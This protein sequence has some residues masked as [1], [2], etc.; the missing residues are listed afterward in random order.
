[1]AGE[2]A[3]QFLPPGT[4]APCPA[5][6]WENGR[7]WCGLIRHPSKHLGLRFDADV[8]L[9]EHFLRAIGAHQGCGMDDQDE[10]LAYS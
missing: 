10:P 9:T 2:I 1:M 4:I 5:L 7:A 3:E 8:A 6:E